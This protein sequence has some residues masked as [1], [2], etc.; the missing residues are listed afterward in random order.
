M[1]R[2]KDTLEQLQFEHNYSEN[3]EPFLTN[4]R[5]TAAQAI[6][7]AGMDMIGED[8]P[9]IVVDEVEV[10]GIKS[11][12]VEANPKNELKAEM[13]KKWKEYCGYEN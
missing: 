7:Q 13:R 2:L 1:S 3:S 12:V 10:G 5:D 8:L 6:Y 11:Q 4:Q 9:D